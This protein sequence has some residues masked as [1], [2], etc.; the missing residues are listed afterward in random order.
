L[1]LL[2]KVFVVLTAVFAIVL[3]CLSIFF[4]ALQVNW[5]D[6]AVARETERDAAIAEKMNAE[7][8]AQVSLAL[9]DQALRDMQRALADEQAESQRLADELARAKGDLAKARNEA[10]AFEAGRT[11]LQEILGVTTGEL[12][13]M[14]KQNQ[15]LLAQN[16]DLQTRNTRMNSRILDLTTNVA[17]LTDQVRNIQEKL[18]AAEQKALE[19]QQQIV[20][21]RPVPAEQEVPGAVPVAAPL[22]GPIEGEIVQVDGNYA[23]ISVGETSGVVR[24]MTFMIYREGAG[25]L[26]DL[27]IDKVRPKDSA[28]KLSTLVK[29]EVRRG[30][31]V[32]YPVTE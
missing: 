32:R 13:A 7:F 1:S 11:K 18:Y 29:G 25:Y 16:M 2:T 30:D 8:T 4:A 14:Q 23:S 31:L 10:L 26:G 9:K 5:R 28:G 24:G 3:S 15:E 27:V 17:I 21:G 22:K 12:K 20:A 6:V 19:L